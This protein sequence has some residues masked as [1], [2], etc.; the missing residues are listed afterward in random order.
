MIPTTPVSPFVVPG[1]VKE[2][3]IAPNLPYYPAMRFNARVMPNAAQT[4]LARIGGAGDLVKRLSAA[5]VNGMDKLKPVDICQ[6]E[7]VAKSELLADYVQSWN[8]KDADG[9]NVPPS[10]DAIASL[11]YFAF[12]RIEAVSAGWEASD[13]DP[14]NQDGKPATREDDKGN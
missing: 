9:N 14:T 4:A 12:L 2:Y 3:Y 6:E 5:G 8:L 11:N 7:I 1:T 10:A 13:P